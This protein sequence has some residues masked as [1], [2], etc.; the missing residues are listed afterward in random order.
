MKARFRNYIITAT[1]RGDKPAK[2]DG[3]N[4]NNHT[5]TVRNT[6][7]GKK[8]SF[9]FWASLADPELSSEYD[10][11][12]AFYCFVSDAIAGE[13]TFEDFCSDFGY[14]NDSMTA[15]KTWKA[16]KRSAAKLSRITTEDIYDLAND[17]SE[18][19]A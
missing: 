9:D 18:N 11:I 15:Y 6:E 10:I 3:R 4:H 19:Y 7:T 12:N 14:D 13:M 2:W 8:T 1:Y 5:V 17:L 16:C